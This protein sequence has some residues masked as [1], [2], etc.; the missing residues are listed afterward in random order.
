MFCRHQWFQTQTVVE[1]AVLAKNMTKERVDIQID[2]QHLRVIIRDAEGEQEYELDLELYGQ[3]S[4]H[5]LDSSTACIQVK[6]ACCALCTS[7]LMTAIACSFSQW[8]RGIAPLWLYI[9]A[10]T[11]VLISVCF[12]IQLFALQTLSLPEQLHGT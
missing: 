8:S 4:C 10:A 9:T 11:V 7:Q 5:L 12:A 3:V 1:V 2:K 6:S